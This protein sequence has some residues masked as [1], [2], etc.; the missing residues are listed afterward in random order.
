MREDEEEGGWGE[1]MM[2]RREDG[3]DEGWVGSECDVVEWTGSGG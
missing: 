2:G 3:E 1:G